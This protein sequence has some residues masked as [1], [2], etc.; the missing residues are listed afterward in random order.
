MPSFFD[1]NDDLQFYVERG[2]PWETLVPLVE[3]R[4]GPGQE[5]ESL[6]EAVSFYRETLALV[7]AFVAEQ[8]A[9]VVP[10]LD[11]QPPRLAGGEVVHPEAFTAIFDQVREMGLHGMCIPRGLGGMGCPMVLYFLAAE[12]F[13]RADVSVMAHFGFHQ[14]IAL[15]LLFHAMQDPSAEVDLDAGTY[16]HLPFRE[17]IE[18]MARGGP[19]G[20][21]TSPRPTR[22]ATW[23]R[24]GAARS[25]TR[26]GAGISR[27]RRSSS[28]RATASTTW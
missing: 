1:D 21:W 15:A 18:E 4:L 17:A 7:G 20:P 13:A 19:G 8:V 10:E 24:Y 28:P 12:L 23:P 26:T 5:H 27:A 2:I 6:E 22:A 14:G 3:P 16:R 9:P 11:R 25:R